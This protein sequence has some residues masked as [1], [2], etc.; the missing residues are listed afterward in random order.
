MVKVLVLPY[1]GEN[2][3]KGVDNMREIKIQS[4]DVL[5][6]HGERLTF[7][8]YLI[9]EQ[10]SVGKSF[11]VESYGVKITNHKE[12]AMISHISVSR[13]TIELL[14]RKLVDNQVGPATLRDVVDDWL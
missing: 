10:V 12:W 2:K 3:S 5:D 8:Y 4:C 13:N 1:N 7:D 14:L 9:V 6:Q 11:D